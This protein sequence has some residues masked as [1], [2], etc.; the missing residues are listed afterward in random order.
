MED[1]KRDF[2]GMVQSPRL[3]IFRRGEFLGG[4]GGQCSLS[5]LFNVSCTYYIF[6]QQAGLLL[7]QILDS[8]ITSNESPLNILLLL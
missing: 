7:F 4:G 2:V 1:E 5:S 3:L 8:V 6:N